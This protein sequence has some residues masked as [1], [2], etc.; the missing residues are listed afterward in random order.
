MTIS[1]LAARTA[2]SFQLYQLSMLLL[3]LLLSLGTSS[4]S[5]FGERRCNSEGSAREKGDVPEPWKCTP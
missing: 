3:S 4:H 5:N 1:R 2:S